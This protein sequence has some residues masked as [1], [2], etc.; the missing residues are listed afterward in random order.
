MTESSRSNPPLVVDLSLL[1]HLTEFALQSKPRY[2]HQTPSEEV[3]RQ[4]ASWNGV[5]TLLQ[6]VYKIYHESNMIPGPV[7]DLMLKL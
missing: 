1:Q 5:L 2:S 4:A 7:P 3:A 6:R